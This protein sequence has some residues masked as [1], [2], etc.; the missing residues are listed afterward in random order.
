MRRNVD[1]FFRRFQLP[2]L[3]VLL[4]LVPGELKLMR[5]KRWVL[6][7]V[8]MALQATRCKPARAWI[9][10][11]LMLSF[12]KRGVW[13]DFVNAKRICRDAVVPIDQR[14]AMRD[15]DVPAPGGLSRLPGALAASDVACA[16]TIVEETVPCVGSL[17]DVSRCLRSSAFQ[18]SECTPVWFFAVLFP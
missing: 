5:K 7:A 8:K 14:N 13:A 11:H 4:F 15:S 1:H 2:G 10:R 6:S 9:V 17:V 12:G 18:R 3:F 16:G